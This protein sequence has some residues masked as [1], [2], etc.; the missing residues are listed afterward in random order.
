MYP[1]A[2]RGLFSRV[3][4]GWGVRISGL[5][6]GVGCVAAIIMVSSLSA[7]RKPGPYFD[8]KTVADSKFLL[9]A[10]GGCFVALG[11][12]AFNIRDFKVE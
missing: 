2:L 10:A 5:V 11:M 9:L 7:Q 3:G 12:Y 4:F 1:I 6:S 8:V